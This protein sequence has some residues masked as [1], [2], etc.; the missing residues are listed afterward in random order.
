M[1]RSIV[2]DVKLLKALVDVEIDIEIMWVFGG[3][4][5]FWLGDKKTLVLKVKRFLDV[6]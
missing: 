4:R 5:E 2:V 6:G 1:N 3:G